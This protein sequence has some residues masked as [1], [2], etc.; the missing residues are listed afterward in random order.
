MASEKARQVIARAFVVDAEL[1]KAF[2]E[3]LDEYIEALIWCGG[4]NDFAIG[5]QARTG[6]EKDVVP[7]ISSIEHVK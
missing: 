7:L 1:A 5:G 6:W 3:V 2:E 4:S